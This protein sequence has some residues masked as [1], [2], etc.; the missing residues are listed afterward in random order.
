MIGRRSALVLSLLVVACTGGER[1]VPDAR[2]LIT[3]RTLG[4]AYLE[5]NNLD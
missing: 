3:I 1:E 4:L 5:E 2:A